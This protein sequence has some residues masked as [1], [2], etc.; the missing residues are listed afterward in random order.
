VKTAIAQLLLDVAGAFKSFMYALFLDSGGV[1]AR[2]AA[3]DGV[4]LLEHFSVT[5]SSLL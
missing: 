5:M 2:F 3:P 1:V 4:M